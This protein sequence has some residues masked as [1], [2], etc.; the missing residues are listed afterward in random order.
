MSP[1]RIASGSLVVSLLVFTAPACQAIIGIDDAT[2]RTEGDGG[3]ASG[4]A[5]GAAADGAPASCDCA[6]KGDVCRP[7][8][9]NA[10]KDACIDDTPAAPGTKCSLSGGTCSED[11]TCGCDPANAGDCTSGTK[12]VCDAST[13]SCRACAND[14]DCEKVRPGSVCDVA[15][16]SCQQ[17]TIA[18]PSACTGATPICVA[19]KCA[20][21]MHDEDCKGNAAGEVCVAGKCQVCS[22]TNAT[23]C[24]GPSPHCDV[25]KAICSSVCSDD[26]TW[27]PT[28]SPQKPICA[29]NGGC[30]EC[31]ASD[32]SKCTADKPVCDAT[33]TCAPCTQDAQCAGKPAGNA[34]LNGACHPCSPTNKTA[35][36]GTTPICGADGK[37][38]KCTSSSDCSG[39]ATGAQCRSDGAC[40]P[41]SSS[42]NG[43]SCGANLVCFGE[44]CVPCVAGSTCTSANVCQQASYSCASG[45]PVCQDTGAK[46]DN[47]PCGASK[48]CEGG[49]CVSC[50]P[51][52]GTSCTPA[53]ACRLGTEVCTAAGASCQES[54]NAPD[55]TVCATASECS[56]GTC[57]TCGALPPSPSNGW[58]AVSTSGPTRY[59][60]AMTYDSI[61]KRV[62]AFGGYPTTASNGDNGTYTWDGASWSTPSMGTKPPARAYTTLVFDAFNG[63][64]VVFGGIFGS[65]TVYNDTWTWDGVSPGWTQIPCSGTCPQARNQAG[66]AY[67]SDRHVIVMFGGQTVDGTALGDTWQLDLSSSTWTALSPSNSP[68]AGVAQMTYDANRKVVVAYVDRGAYGIW[69]YS[70]ATN[71]WFDHSSASPNPGRRAH[72]RAV[73]DSAQKRTVLFGGCLYPNCVGSASDDYHN[74]R[75]EWD[76]TCWRNTTNS[77]K[78]P[79]LLQLFGMAFDS[80]NLK[81]VIF[82]GAVW[83]SGPV[84][85]TTWQ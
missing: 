19:G 70:A 46:P 43:V 47:T 71:T 11:G 59:G 37:C 21:C 13:R 7:K 84:S 4:R 55:G 26:P 14:H 33:G 79:G 62:I 68:S 8:K 85:A 38:T 12:P 29:P 16:G 61:R 76:G 17:C 25:A 1:L 42:M 28:H 77:A 83:P 22:A 66:L 54:G 64:T 56:S 10:A 73:Y 51:A 69:E 32:L 2:A 52:P 81:T 45:Q 82:G 35:C 49:S 50:S 40:G 75:W 72:S 58:T 24:Q 36:S 18:N 9:C 65:S 57:K 30:T 23:A 5:D 63:K 48:Y 39:N 6:D 67:D 31:S 20:P 74:D 34:C 15:T 80:T 60:H 27:C 53:N 78:S 3:A 41:C 44:S